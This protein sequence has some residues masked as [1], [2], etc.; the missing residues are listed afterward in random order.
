MPKGLN[1]NSCSFLHPQ[2]YH[3][4][5][6]ECEL[7][8]LWLKAWNGLLGFPKWTQ[9]IPTRGVMTLWPCHSHLKKYLKAKEE[10][11]KFNISPCKDVIFKKHPL[12]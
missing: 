4:H 2:G 11:W 1:L 10:L 6:W 12:K 9:G 8:C 3:F 7:L 5:A